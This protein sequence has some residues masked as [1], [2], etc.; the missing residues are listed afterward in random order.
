MDK[1]ISLFVC[2]FL[3]LSERFFSWLC[4]LDSHIMTSAGFAVANRAG[5]GL[6]YSTSLIL[7]TCSSENTPEKDTLNLHL[8]YLKIP[9]LNIYPH[10]SL[11]ILLIQIANQNKCL[12]F[13]LPVFGTNVEMLYSNPPGLC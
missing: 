4:C 5:K 10:Y 11:G 13:F 7:A 12:P 1:H 3:K 6:G 8:F 9:H 2:L